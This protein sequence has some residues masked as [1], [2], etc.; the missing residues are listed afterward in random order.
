[1]RNL[2]PGDRGMVS[3]Y[4]QCGRC[5]NCL[6]GGTHLCTDPRRPG[7]DR[8]GNYAEFIAVRQDAAVPLPP[9]VGDDEAACAQLSFGTAFHALIRRGGLRAAETVLIAGAGGGV[10][11]AAVQVAKLSDAVVSAAAGSREK[12]DLARGLGADAV[13]NYRA[14]DLTEAVRTAT[15]DRG[16]DMVLDGIGGEF[17]RAG[18]ACL[19]QGGRSSE[20]TAASGRRST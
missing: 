13:V 3:A 1:M 7:I 14:E 17:L 6:R 16:V 5:E 19:R 9:E 4:P 18:V 11:S 8:P 20:P 15:R 12:L 10:G 2:R